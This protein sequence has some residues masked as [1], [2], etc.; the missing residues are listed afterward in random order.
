MRSQESL[1]F[2][3]SVESMD[4]STDSVRHTKVD[5][6]WANTSVMTFVNAANERAVMVRHAT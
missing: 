1:G 6:G 4:R 5:R 3:P 2:L